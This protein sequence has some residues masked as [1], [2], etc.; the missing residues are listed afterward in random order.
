MKMKHH[1]PQQY[2]IM[3]RVVQRRGQHRQSARSL[4]PLGAHR[5]TSLTTRQSQKPSER[6]MTLHTIISIT[7]VTHYLINF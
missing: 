6:N 3:V 5:Y 1:Q 4:H 7:A 2:V